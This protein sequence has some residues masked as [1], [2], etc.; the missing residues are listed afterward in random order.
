MRRGE[1][2]GPRGQRW[3]VEVPDGRR[4]R[5]RGLLGRESIGPGEGMLFEGARSVHTVGMRFPIVAA[6]LGRPGDDGRRIV[7][8]AL[9]LPPG[10]VTL[11]RPGSDSV[12][13]LAAG[14]DVRV[15]DAILCRLPTAGSDARAPI[16]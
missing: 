1:A 14:S 4:E 11:P 13:E 16:V 7:R 10:R 3:V 12:L 2:I 6:F 5:A 9:A 8:R 15:G